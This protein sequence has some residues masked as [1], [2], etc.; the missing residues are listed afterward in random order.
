MTTVAAPAGRRAVVSTLA[1][2][3]VAQ[4]MLI[5]D[6]DVVNV[7]LP[8]IR[9]TLEVSEARLQLVAVAYPLTFGSLLIVFGRAGDLFGR[10]HLFLSGVA[11]FTV[12]SL[13]TGLAGSEW[14]LVAARA[15]QGVGAAMVSPTARPP[16][17]R[18][19]GKCEWTRH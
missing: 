16:R 15:A 19:V 9:E 13:A 5:V 17:H 10:R 3:C 14:Q 11:V 6:V 8:S 4:F 7:A 2:P 12:A 1:V 18:R